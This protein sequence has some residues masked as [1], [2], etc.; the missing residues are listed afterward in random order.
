LHR[1]SCRSNNHH[2]LCFL[3]DVKI[4]GI[5]ILVLQILPKAQFRPTTIKMAVL[6][7]K[8]LFWAQ[9]HPSTIKMTILVL[10]LLFLGSSRPSSY[11]AHHVAKPY[12]QKPK[13]PTVSW[14][15]CRNTMSLLPV[16]TIL[17]PSN[18]HRT[19]IPLAQFVT[20]AHLMPSPPSLSVT[21]SWDQK[22]LE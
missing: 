1:P 13:T 6:V 3:I 21:K 9:F 20:Q 14:W 11:M 19:K 17:I 2:P 16:P 4:I 22:L 5:A 12:Q 8:I 18:M 7:L 10:K 15:Q